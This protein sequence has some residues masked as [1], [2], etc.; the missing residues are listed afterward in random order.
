MFGGRWLV[1][2][3]FTKWDLF[4]IDHKTPPPPPLWPR[5]A[6]AFLG[7]SPNLA[8]QTVQPVDVLAEVPHISED[9]GTFHLVTFQANECSIVD[10]LQMDDA[11]V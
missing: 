3:R 1:P 7:P 8:P 4:A 2:V 5:L 10:N 9:L 6:S 11:D